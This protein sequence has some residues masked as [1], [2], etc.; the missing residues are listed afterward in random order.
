MFGKL[1]RFPSPCEQTHPASCADGSCG[2]GGGVG[3][4]AAHGARTR[5]SR[6]PCGDSKVRGWRS[7]RSPID[8]HHSIPILKGWQKL[9][10]AGAFAL[11]FVA[12]VK[13]NYHDQDFTLS[14]FDHFSATLEDQGITFKGDGNPLKI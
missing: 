5:A 6:I 2:G 3:P 4:V 13:I 9:F 11:V 14:G 10:T 12:Q 8:A 1:T 7:S